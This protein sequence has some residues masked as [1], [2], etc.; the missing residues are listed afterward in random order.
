VGRWR[1]K[2]LRNKRAKLA[3]PQVDQRD[4][5]VAAIDLLMQGF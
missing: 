3:F 1:D 2:A 5:I 4:D